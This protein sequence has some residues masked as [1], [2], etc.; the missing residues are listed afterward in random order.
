MIFVL[1]FTMHIEYSKQIRCHGINQSINKFFRS[2]GIGGKRKNMRITKSIVI[3]HRIPC[4]IYAQLNLNLIW[5][6]HDNPSCIWGMTHDRKHTQC[7]T[8]VHRRTHICYQNED[9]FHRQH[10]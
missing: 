9:N 10:A 5:S 2:G 4:L 6:L 1:M 3:V 8:G 7:R